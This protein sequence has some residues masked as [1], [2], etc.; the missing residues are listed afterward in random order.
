MSKGTIVL[1]CQI[2][3][4]KRNEL[5]FISLWIQLMKCEL[6]ELTSL[7][8]HVYAVEG[9]GTDNILPSCLQADRNLRIVSMLR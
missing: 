5:Q 2:K 9:S 7:A 3:K 8:R 4:Q 1:Q 6:T